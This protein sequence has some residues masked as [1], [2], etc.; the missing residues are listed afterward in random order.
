VNGPL[1]RRVPLAELAAVI[2]S[3]NSGPYEL[4]LDVIFRNKND[5]LHLKEQDFFTPVLI[6]GLYRVDPTDVLKIVY[7]DP[8][9]AVKAT[10][11]RP[12]PSGALG[13]T[14]IYGAQQH[15]PLL[16]LMVEVRPG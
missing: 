8:A 11:R 13:D 4:T 1:P 5:Y 16:G 7:F 15:A 2:R 14:D 9:L 12:V 6:A 10:M 3:K